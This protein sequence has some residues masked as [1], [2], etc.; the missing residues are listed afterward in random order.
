MNTWNVA[1]ANEVLAEQFAAWVNQL[2]LTVEGLG[3]RSALLR[4]P[5]DPSI[6]R[7]G[8]VVS[9][10]AIAALADTA[11][12]FAIASAAGGFR[13]MATVDLHTTFMRGVT[14]A[15]I[16]ADAV[17]ERLGR[18]LAFVRVAM[19]A[20]PRNGSTKIDPNAIVATAIGTF[21]LP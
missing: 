3:V 6:C 17:V 12:V 14:E 4:L 18:Q 9:G 20:S 7:S 1:T 2:G 15:D 8:G 21:A 5:F 10:Q 11:M 13:P 19:R 16:L